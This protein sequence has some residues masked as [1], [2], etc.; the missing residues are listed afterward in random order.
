MIPQRKS[1]SP[2]RGL[3]GSQ[4]TVSVEYA[5]N[6]KFLEGFL[7]LFKQSGEE[8]KHFAFDIPIFINTRLTLWR[9]TTYI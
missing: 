8:T 9:L 4:D 6:D 7:P 5:R 3:N 1:N 2:A